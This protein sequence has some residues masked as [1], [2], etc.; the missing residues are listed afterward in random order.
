MEVAG[1]SLLRG[2]PNALVGIH[3]LHTLLV[4][5]QV[6]ELYLGILECLDFIEHI[7]GVLIWQQPEVHSFEV[8]TL[9]PFGAVSLG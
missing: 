6:Q 7:G 4:R 3:V 8:E 2:H 1:D 9:G 5:L